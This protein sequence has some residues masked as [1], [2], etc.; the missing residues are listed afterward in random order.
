MNEDDSKEF[1]KSPDG[2]IQ[3]NNSDTKLIVDGLHPF[4]VYAFRVQA[5]NAVGL[6][7]PSKQSYPAITLM[8]SECT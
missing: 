2:P 3:T 8:E 5:V 1:K 4:T 7:R 6:S